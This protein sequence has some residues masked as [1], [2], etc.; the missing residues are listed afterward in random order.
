M[1]SG[2]DKSRL[3]KD[4]GRAPST[5]KQDDPA[6]QLFEYFLTEILSLPPLSEINSSELDEDMENIMTGYS[7]Y[8]QN[9]NIPVNHRAYLNDTTKLPTSFLKYTTLKEYLSKAVNLMTKTF[10]DNEFLKD[11]EAVGDISG[12]KFEKV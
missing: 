9:T 2:I 12:K 11:K 1:S 3:S 8:L 6:I 5:T 4:V 10:P 7:V